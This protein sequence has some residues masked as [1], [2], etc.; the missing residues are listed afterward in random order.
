MHERINN[1]SEKNCIIYM[2]ATNPRKNSVFFLGQNRVYKKDD[3]LHITCNG[4][5]I[6]M[7]EEIEYLGVVLDQALKCSC[8]IDKIVSKSINNLKFLY[9]IYNTGTLKS[10][11]FKWQIKI[12]IILAMAQCQ[13][14]YACAMWFSRISISAKKRLQIVQNKVIRFVLRIHPRTHL[15]CSEFNRVNISLSLYQQYI[16]NNH[17]FKNNVKAYLWEKL[18]TVDQDDYIY[19]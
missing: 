2:Y 8:I 17:L 18:L 19:F 13:Y 10:K 15:G 1:S 4:Q 11:G 16:T 7:K 5:D 9:T 14:D 12:M 3:K 6:E